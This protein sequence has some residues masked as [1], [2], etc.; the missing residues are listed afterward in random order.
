MWAPEE[1]SQLSVL[2]FDLD[3]TLLDSFSSH[4]DA[5]QNMFA[6][7]GIEVNRDRFL[8]SYSPN[9]Y[10]T[11][12]AMGL[13]PE[14][15]KL[16]NAYWLEE[17]DRRQPDLF[18]GVRDTLIRLSERYPLGLITS[19][20]SSRVS[21]DLSRTEIASVFQTIITGD[22]VKNPKPSPEGL[23]LALE[24]IGVRPNQVAY[25]GDALHD[26]EMAQA[27]S[28]RF[29]GVASDFG[30]LPVDHPFP[31]INSVTDLIRLLELP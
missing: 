31:R 29:I 26:Y 1:L 16:A 14:C 27:A 11:Y 20:S 19:G 9:W 8:E 12:E 17:A 28:T 18:P 5:Y 24:R 4:F 22:D 21:R 2:L 15:W 30:G 25:I 13:P 7:F 6:R 23:E 10:H 3:G